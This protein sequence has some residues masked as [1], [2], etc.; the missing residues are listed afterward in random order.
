MSK[1][2]D[3]LHLPEDVR[4]CGSC[5]QWVPLS[6]FRRRSG[7]GVAHECRDCHN[8]Q[9][10]AQARRQRA[11]A[12]RKEF[13]SAIAEVNNS[14]T[15]DDLNAACTALLGICRGARGF[16]QRFCDH[17]NAAKPGSQMRTSMLMAG[18]RL[19]TEQASLDDRSGS[20]VERMS[21]A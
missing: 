10:A 19:L 6:Q 18:L 1:I 11:R 15:S 2:N 7:G 13:Q 8:M 16:A 12:R 17:F 20:E 4:L 3:E 21:D 9:R 14:V 5:R